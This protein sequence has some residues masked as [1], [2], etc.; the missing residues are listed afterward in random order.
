MLISLKLC[1]S[2][3]CMIEHC[4]GLPSTHDPEVNVIGISVTWVCPSG[5]GYGLV[6][7]ETAPEHKL[8]GQTRI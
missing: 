4:V 6:I 3:H 7:K 1:T 5:Q 8:T 2:K